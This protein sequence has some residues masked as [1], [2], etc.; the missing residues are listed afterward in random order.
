MS[1]DHGSYK[2]FLSHSQCISDEVKLKLIADGFKVYIGDWDGIIK[3]A[4]IIEW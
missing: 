2:I 1:N 4:L 3:N